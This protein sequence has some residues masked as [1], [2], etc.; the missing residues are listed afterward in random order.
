M[1]ALTN[2]APTALSCQLGHAGL[3]GFFERRFSVEAVGLFKPA[4][5]T[6]RYAAN[7][8][9]V[10]IASVLMIAAHDWDVTGAIR[11]GAKGAFVARTGMVLGASAETPDV[12]GADLLEI[13]A[14]L[15]ALAP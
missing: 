15:L 6:Y 10:E 13:A 8:L 4:P 9:G 1:D 12:V 2:S 7:Q 11:A 14:K 5:E 3:T